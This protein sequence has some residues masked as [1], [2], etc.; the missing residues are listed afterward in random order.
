MYLSVCLLILF[1]ILVIRLLRNTKPLVI[2]TTIAFQW[3]FLLGL[4]YVVSVLTI[5]EVLSDMFGSDYFYF[6]RPD[7]WRYLFEANLFRSDILSIDGL[8]GQFHFY[9]ATPKFGLSSLLAIYGSVFGELSAKSALLLM[10]AS[11]AGIAVYFVYCVNR[12]LKTA[13]AGKTASLFF[14]TF[15][16]FFP[17]DYYWNLLLLREA[18]ANML[19]LAALAACYY[20]PLAN[21]AHYSIA[22]LFCLMLVFFRSQLGVIASLSLGYIVIVNSGIKWRLLLPIVF[23]FLL[24]FSQAFRAAGFSSIGQLARGLGL[25]DTVG[26]M[27]L[28]KYEIGLSK[29]FFWLI[30]AGIVSAVFVPRSKRKTG[31]PAWYFFAFAMV[32]CVLLYAFSRGYQIRLL[33][34]LFILAKLHLLFFYSSRKLRG[35]GGFST[36][37]GSYP[38]HRRQLA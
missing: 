3:C 29:I 32:F 6:M 20:A 28:L 13:A 12:I 9:T 37:T 19:L 14:I 33:Y 17:V 38:V 10:N 2:P 31:S 30:C 25:E 1:F 4:T 35:G 27:Q 16:L 21:R 34:P 26:T 36:A 18:I 8:A 11:W 5:T 23:L 24:S 15:I 22:L 7:S